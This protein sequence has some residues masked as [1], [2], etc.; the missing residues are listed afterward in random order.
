MMKMSKIKE[1]SREQTANEITNVK[2]IKGNFLYSKEEYIF[3][4]LRVYPYNLELLSK[5]ERRIKTQN[6]SLSF[7]GDRRAF[8]YVALP[9]E[10]DLDDYKNYLKRKHQE[11]L[12]NYGKRQ[13]LGIM[14]REAGI[15]S[16]SGENYEH[17]HFFKLWAKVGKNINDTK[18]ELMA[19]MEEFK[20]RYASAAIETEILGETEI[21]KLCNLYTNNQQISFMTSVDNPISTTIPMIEDY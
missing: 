11:E 6:L 2:D 16:S 9:R 1:T 3:G 13:I 15:L 21:F 5:E 7:E 20:Q 17:H 12:S 14:I 4:Y 10:V 18:N 19:R 8:D